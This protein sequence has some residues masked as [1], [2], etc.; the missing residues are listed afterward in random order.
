MPADGHSPQF[1]W[2][3]VDGTALMVADA[4]EDSPG[5]PVLSTV[6]ETRAGG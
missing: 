5:S 6:G 2:A 4:L 1:I 3:S